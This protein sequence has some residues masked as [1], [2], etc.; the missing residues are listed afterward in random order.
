[1]MGVFAFGWVLRYLRLVW[2]VSVGC[3]WF[4]WLLLLVGLGALWGLVC[5]IGSNFGLLF[6]DLGFWLWFK[7]ISYLFGLIFGL[8]LD[9]YVCLLYKNPIVCS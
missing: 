1:M 3:G 9:L 4:L 6:Y 7:C 2:S 5:A 8:L